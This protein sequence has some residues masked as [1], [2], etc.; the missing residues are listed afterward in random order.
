MLEAHKVRGKVAA[1]R[2][3]QPSSVPAFGAGVLR[4]QKSSATWVL[5]AVAV[6][7][8]AVAFLMTR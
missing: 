6:V 5:L 3:P 1:T 7:A 8:G 2:A 4:A